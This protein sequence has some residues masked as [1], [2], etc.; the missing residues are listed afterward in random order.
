MK[1][2]LTKSIADRCQWAST[3]RKTGRKYVR[4]RAEVEMLRR[5]HELGI[6][7]ET[8]GKTVIV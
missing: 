1:Y 8:D 4:S 3:E 5:P 6:S 2:Y 7:V